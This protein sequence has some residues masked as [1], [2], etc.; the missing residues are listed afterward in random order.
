[1]SEHPNPA[2]ET[3]ACLEAAL[4]DAAAR[5]MKPAMPLMLALGFFQAVTGLSGCM[6]QCR[7]LAGLPAEWPVELVALLRAVVSAA[8]ARRTDGSVTEAQALRLVRAVTGLIRSELHAMPAPQ[9]PAKTAKK[10][11][12]KPVAPRLAPTSLPPAPPRWR[13]DEY[14]GVGGIAIR[15]FRAAASP[16]SI[17][18]DA[19]RQ[20]VCRLPTS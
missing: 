10:P 8:N 3:L 14:E 18:A 1:M 9:K 15:V 16:E 6:R 20:V 13:R 2:V 4:R 12:P 5:A 7:K 17:M 19:V 11:A